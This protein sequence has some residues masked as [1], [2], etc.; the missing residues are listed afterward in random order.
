MIKNSHFKINIDTLLF[1]IVYFLTLIAL[2][3]LNND[4]TSSN[5]IVLN[6]I[7]S[8]FTFIFLVILL[9]LLFRPIRIPAKVGIMILGCL[10]SCCIVFCFRFYIVVHWIYLFICLY[11]VLSQGRVN[12][13]MLKISIY[14]TFFSLLLQL[15]FF[16]FVDGRPVLSYI[17]PNYSSYYIFCFFLFIWFLGYKKLAILLILCGLLTLSRAYF[18]AVIIF[19]IVDKVN[20]VR[21]FFSYF[22]YTFLLLV[23][24]V[25]LFVVSILYISYFSDVVVQDVGGTKDVTQFVD[26]S[27]LDRVTAN[28]LFINDFG[29]HIEK[30]F[31]GV[32]LETYT[33][34]IFR[35]SPH[36]SL[37]QLVL[38][39]GLFFSIFYFGILAFIF[40]LFRVSFN[41]I[42][43]YLSL[44]VYFLVLGGGI[45]GIQV[46][47]LAF[48]Y[49][50]STNTMVSETAK[51]NT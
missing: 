32:D 10:V 25:L 6:Y 40:K 48:I 50:A 36:N 37:L 30:Y 12:A 34:T 49:K 21:R 23:G 27:N 8:G 28:V 43:A 19:F 20:F 2:F 24:Y 3:F 42:V 29:E 38:N 1:N 44:L 9:T 17:D 31:W 15:A 33:K 35:N 14:L 51:M 7:L 4:R 5:E 11:I 46:I 22:D 18:L 47:W 45:Y 41:Y 26:Q 13:K 39:Y 16:R